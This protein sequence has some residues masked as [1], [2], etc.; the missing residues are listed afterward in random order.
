M[1]VKRITHSWGIAGGCWTLALVREVFAL[2]ISATAIRVERYDVFETPGMRWKMIAMLSIGAASD[3]LIAAF[4]CGGILRMRSGMPASDKVVDR[5]VA[6][7]IGA[8][9][10][11]ALGQRAFSRG[12]SIRAAHQYC[13]R[14]GNGHGASRGLRAARRSLTPVQY[15]ALRNCASIPAACTA[16][17]QARSHLHHVLLHNSEAVR[18]LALRVA[19]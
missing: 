7:T 1:R 3:L 2:I 6:F 18:Q 12:V 8:S 9:P 19:Q 16:L 10:S 14:R 15:L 13:C 5:I 4:I 11:R 17:T